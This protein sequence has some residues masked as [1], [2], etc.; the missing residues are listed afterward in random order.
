MTA[1]QELFAGLALIEF[2]LTI[3]HQ[4]IARVDAV[5]ILATAFS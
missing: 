5:D 2:T 1:A 4:V 3:G